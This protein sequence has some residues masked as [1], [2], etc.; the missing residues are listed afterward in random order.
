[1]GTISFFFFYESIDKYLLYSSTIVGSC[2]LVLF[3]FFHS[4][5]RR[6]WFNSFY[7]QVDS[8]SSGESHQPK[9]EK[10]KRKRSKMDRRISVLQSF[11]FISN[12]FTTTTDGRTDVLD[13]I[14]AISSCPR[15]SQLSACLPGNNGRLLSLQSTS[16]GNIYERMMDGWYTRGARSRTVVVAKWRTRDG[17]RES[18]AHGR[19]AELN[20][21]NGMLSRLGGV[22]LNRSNTH[23]HRS[24]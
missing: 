2:I 7:I 15:W 14:N 8:R 5:H 19:S 3:S 16:R 12:S 18:D 1:M 4:L 21:S 20:G 13:N 17:Q 10:S 22:E 11:S 6:M 23:T 9:R 24:F